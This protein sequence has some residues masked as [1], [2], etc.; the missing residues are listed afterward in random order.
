MF[1]EKNIIRVREQIKNDLPGMQK[2]PP[3]V[4]S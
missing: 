2:S 4:H 1:G 3:Q